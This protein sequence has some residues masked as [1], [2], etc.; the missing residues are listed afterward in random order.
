MDMWEALAPM[1]VSIVFFLTIGGVLI[2]RPIAKHLGAYLEVLTRQQ[3]EGSRS[4]EL[5]QLRETLETMDQR[6]QLMEERQDFNER[7]L[8]R[9]GELGEGGDA[10]SA[11]GP[12][13]PGAD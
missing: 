9:R 4:S 7:L 5:L 2:L 10:G 6:L 12:G 11:L 3:L 8:E 1:V 13:I